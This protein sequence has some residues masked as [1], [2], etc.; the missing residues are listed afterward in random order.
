MYASRTWNGEDE[1][2]KGR[3]NNDPDHWAAGPHGQV[4]DYLQVYFGNATVVT[5]IKPFVFSSNIVL[6]VWNDFCRL[7]CLFVTRVASY[8]PEQKITIIQNRNKN[9]RFNLQQAEALSLSARCPR[10]FN[11]AVCTLSLYSDVN[12]Y[13]VTK[14]C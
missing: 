8:T 14:C 5:G 10:V 6:N 2:W 1:G 3:L 4:G 9:I 7:C 13:D 12:K 11:C